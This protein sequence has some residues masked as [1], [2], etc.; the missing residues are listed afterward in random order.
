MVFDEKDI[1]KSIKDAVETGKDI[2]EIAKDVE[3][4]LSPGN[5]LGDALATLVKK[6]TA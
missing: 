4:L 3:K 5:I 6:M 2:V 1:G